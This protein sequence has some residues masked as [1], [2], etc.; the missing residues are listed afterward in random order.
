MK[1]TMPRWVILVGAAVLV[2]AACSKS[3]PAA[4]GTASP[5]AT[6]ESPTPPASAGG[7]TIPIGND[8]ANDHGTKDV[9]GLTTVT[10]EQHNDSTYY[11]DPTVLSGSTGQAITVHVEN[12]GS[13]PHT[14]T[15]DAQEISVQLQPGDEKDVQVTLPASGTVEFYCSFHHG[16]GMAGELAVA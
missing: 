9:T 15:I 14:F 2:L 8:V 13:V 3:T 5:P 7:G 6:T 4:T 11:F 10:V 16:Q 1:R 12:K